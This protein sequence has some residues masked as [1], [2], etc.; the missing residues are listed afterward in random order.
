[1]I[2]KAENE[3]LKGIPVTAVKIGQEVYLVDL[4]WL[5]NQLTIKPTPVFTEPVIR[6]EPPQMPQWV[7]PINVAI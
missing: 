7:N 6:Y 3:M 2:N 1:M 5:A 4:R